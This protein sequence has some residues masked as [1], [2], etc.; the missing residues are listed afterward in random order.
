MSG[1][2]QDYMD[3]FEKN[4]NFVLGLP[5]MNIFFCFTLFQREMF[6]CSFEY[7]DFSIIFLYLMKITNLIKCLPR[8]N[9]FDG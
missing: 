5:G 6:T 9:T 8:G 2:L 4:S 3:F 1:K 7:Q